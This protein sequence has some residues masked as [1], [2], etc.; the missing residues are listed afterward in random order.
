MKETGT[1]AGNRVTVTV[2][3]NIGFHRRAQELDVEVD[4]TDVGDRY[5]YDMSNYGWT[6]E[7]EKR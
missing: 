2:M 4:T 5:M 7:Y 3:S 1:L 6:K